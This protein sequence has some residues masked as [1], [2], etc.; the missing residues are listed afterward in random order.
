MKA[1]LS[2]VT[3]AI[4]LA[5][6]RSGAAHAY[7]VDPCDQAAVVSPPASSPASAASASALAPRTAVV[8]PPSNTVQPTYPKDALDQGIEGRVVL[9]VTIDRQGA[10]ESVVVRSSPHPLLTAA[11][12]AA[13][14]QWK[15]RAPVV[16]GQPMRTRTDVPIVFKIE[17]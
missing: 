9:R 15:F 5:L 4:V 1:T 17:D 11:A 8:C 12:E 2:P 13:V 14:R 16:D 7:N 10:I 6:C 3:V